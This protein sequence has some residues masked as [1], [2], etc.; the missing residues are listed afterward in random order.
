MSVEMES[1]TNLR[2]APGG[3]SRA[4][5]HRPSDG[6]HKTSPPKNLPADRDTISRGGWVIWVGTRAILLSGSAPI[7]R[8]RWR[9]RPRRGLKVVSHV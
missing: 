7:H 4:T 1:L 3:P 2:R 8:W 6:D 5:S 9:L